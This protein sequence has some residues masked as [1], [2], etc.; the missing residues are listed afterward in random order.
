[1][2]GEAPSS[3]CPQ[4]VGPT[5]GRAAALGWEQAFDAE[6]LGQPGQ[7]LFAVVGDVAQELLEVLAA[8][9]LTDQRAELLEV[10]DGA[11]VN[12]QAQEQVAAGVDQGRELGIAAVEAAAP[13]AEVA[14][15]VT[16]L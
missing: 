7:A 3:G 5:G 2:F 16:G 4:L 12:H 10:V 13:L 8:I 14:R 6:G 11:A 9:R 1:M 15:D